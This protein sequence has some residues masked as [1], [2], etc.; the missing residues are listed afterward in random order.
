MI[1]TLL[2]PS[3]KIALSV[4]NSPVRSKWGT[5]HRTGSEGQRTLSLK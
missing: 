3:L 2:L 4:A 1:E 5:H